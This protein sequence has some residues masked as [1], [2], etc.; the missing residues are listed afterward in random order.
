MRATGWPP[1]VPWLALAAVTT[2]YAG[3]V[4]FVIPALE[5]QKVIPD[6]AR[7]VAAQADPADRV[8]TYRLTR[9]NTAFR[10]YVDRHVT[11]LDDQEQMAAFFDGPDP[12]YV[13][14]LEPDYRHFLARGVP[15]EE[16]YSR[17]G[18]FVTSGRALWRRAPPP[19][20]FVV[21]TR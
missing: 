21:V 11:M 19:T 15:L 8:G 20:R 4:L 5:S 3:L 10:F 18:M 6:V 13:V 17:D 9:W 7:W 12:F 1:R 16:A 14:M 2:I